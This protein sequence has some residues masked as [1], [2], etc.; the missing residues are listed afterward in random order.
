MFS[1][2]NSCGM[3]NLGDREA[4]ET[5]TDSWTQM[6]KMICGFYTFIKTNHDETRDKTH[7]WN[8][9]KEKF[10]KQKGSWKTSQHF[11]SD[12]GFEF[13]TT[14]WEINLLLTDDL[15]LLRYK[16]CLFIWKKMHQI[17]SCGH[18]II[19]GQKNGLFQRRVAKIC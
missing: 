3:F 17:S 18:K 19:W 4:R 15:C 9:W 7:V 13:G 16:Q 1:M 2:R 6:S 5:M 8:L 14:F 11:F 12:L 10:L